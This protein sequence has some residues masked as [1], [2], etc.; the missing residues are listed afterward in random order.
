MNKIIK[1]LLLSDILILTSFG[2]IDPIIAIFYKDNL[3]GGTI[4]TAGL[5]SSI[6]LLVKSVIQ[7]PFAKYI[8]SNNI[9]RFKWLL[10]GTILISIV[11]FLYIFAEN[12]YLIY[13]AQIIHG[14]G[15][16]LAFPA[17]LSLWSTNLDK[18]KEGFE[19][20]LHST[21]TGIGTAITAA[22]GATIAEFIGFK[23]TFIFVGVIS[24]IGCIVLLGI[25]YNRKKI[26]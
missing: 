6:F 1:L 21:A 24:L 18:G 16:G 2:L 14:I 22:I 17:W 25:E 3:I 5:A 26:K 7:L 11:P 4:L 20:S 8:D 9:K 12:M 10:I 15:S 13:I 19:W 23:Q